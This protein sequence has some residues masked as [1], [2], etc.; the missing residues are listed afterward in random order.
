MGVNSS[1][2]EPGS[3]QAAAILQLFILLTLISAVIL[4][5]VVGVTLYSSIRY[6]RRAEA[7]ENAEPR[8]IFGHPRLEMIWTVGPF[9]LLT[10]LFILTVSTM[11]Q[12]DPAVHGQAPD[13]IITGHQWWWEVAYPKAGFVTANEI[14]L[15]AGQ[16]LLVQLE[17][18]D[19]IHDFWVPKLGR[20]M[21]MIPGHT[22]YLWVEASTP[23]LYL[24]ACSEFCG[25]QHA[26]MRLR[27]IAQTPA[28]FDA[29]Q[30]G[31]LQSPPPLV[32]AGA[33]TATAPVSATVAQRVTAASAIT[34]TA[35]MTLAVQGAQ[36]FQALTC[37]N[38][39]AIAGTGATA[40]VGPN[41]THV[42]SRQ[43]LGAGVLENTPANLQKWIENP[44]A[45]KPGNQMPHFQLSQADVAALVAYLE[46]L[47]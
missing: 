13:L 21:D 40:T 2:F 30:Q 1:I 26:W 20:K 43:T 37:K 42:A 16:R 17:A 4:A 8:Q 18:A 45:V 46:T 39:H 15:P 11:Q 35:S 28:A 38:C 41:L 33:L 27:V 47:Q 12:A 23:G 44:Q 5:L 7:A 31:Q 6:R 9:L 19:V 22:N 3:P 36:R 25:A 10:S 34:A 24:G 32:A 14:H 29:W